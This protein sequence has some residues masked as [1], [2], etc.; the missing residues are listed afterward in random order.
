MTRLLDLYNHTD[1]QLARVIQER[2]GLAAIAKAGGN[3]GQM[4][5]NKASSGPGA[6]VRAYFAEAAGAAAKFL[7]RPD[8][9]RI[10]ALSFDGWD[11][12]ADEGIA[13]GRLASLLGA[14]DGAIG[15]VESNMGV[16]WKDTVVALVTEFGRTARINGT[17]GTDH[18]TATVALLAGGALKGGRV[19]AD[20]PG[21]GEAALYEKRDLKPTT[22]LRAVLKGL[23]K[24]HVRVNEKAL[25]TTVFPGSANVKPMTGLV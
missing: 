25:A 21:V 18:G 10:G 14:L 1:P 7:A 5:P 15:A 3:M 8:G 4:P 16:A 2:M 6:A 17:E 11:T 13:S 24:D 9:P 20:W 19:I 23:L 12:H 22:D